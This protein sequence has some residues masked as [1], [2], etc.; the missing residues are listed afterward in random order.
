MLTVDDVME[1]QPL[2][3]L[4]NTSLSEAARVM[5]ST[6]CSDLMVTDAE[7]LFQGV[8]SEG[9]VLRTCLPA[10]H[11]LGGRSMLSAGDLLE[12]R[13]SE[14]ANRSV[15]PMILRGAIRLAPTDSLMRA[16]AVMASMQIRRLPVVDA[17]G[18]LVG[19]LSR[20]DLLTGL[21]G[22]AR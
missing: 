4:L 11:D 12:R 13:A 22:H 20:G 7:G 16:A 21:F 15:E 6:G 17:Q 8:V 2:V 19:S 10:Y 9:D 5:R 3:I 1:D 14:V 18:R